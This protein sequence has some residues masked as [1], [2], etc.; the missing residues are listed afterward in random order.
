[1]KTVTVIICVAA[2]LAASMAWAHTASTTV[3]ITARV[4]AYAEW[5]D[6]APVIVETNWSGPINHMNQPQT[7]SRPIT[8]YTNTDVVIAAKPGLNAGV[9]TNGTQHLVT[10]YRMG[11]AVTAPDGAFKPAGSGSGEFFNGLNTYKVV[12]GAGVGTYDLRLDVQATSPADAAPPTGLYTCAV[13]LTL[14]W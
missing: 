3:T 13:I 10:A 11:G 9:L 7:V 14:E 12:Y 5:A 4:D 8:L 6:A 1:M 2:L